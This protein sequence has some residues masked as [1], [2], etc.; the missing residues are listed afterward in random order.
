MTLK[1]DAS[2]RPKPFFSRLCGKAKRRLLDEDPDE[3]D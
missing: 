3:T 2:L 1:K